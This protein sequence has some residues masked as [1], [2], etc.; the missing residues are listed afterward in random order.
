[1]EDEIDSVPQQPGSCQTRT[2]YE[3][4]QMFKTL[5]NPVRRDIIKFI[6]VQGRTKN[7]IME[8]LAL[9][10]EQVKFQLDFLVE[11]CYAQVD[12]DTCRLNDKGLGLLKGIK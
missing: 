10:G 3:H 2:P 1:M 9:S 8:K 6:G 5:E 7:E 4:R 12:G 11:M